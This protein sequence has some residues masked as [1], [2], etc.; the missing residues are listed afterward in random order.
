MR[1]IVH[2][3]GDLAQTFGRQREGVLARCLN[4]YERARKPHTSKISEGGDVEEM[5]A[6]GAVWDDAK[7]RNWAKG[8]IGYTSIP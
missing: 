1:S 8:G 6:P 2:H 5:S 3:I 7:L 4:L